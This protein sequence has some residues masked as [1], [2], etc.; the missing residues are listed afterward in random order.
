MRSILFGLMLSAG[1]VGTA[2]ADQVLASSPAWSGTNQKIGVC[3]LY[4]S[5]TSK[6]KINKLDIIMEQY[7]VVTATTVD[8]CTGATLQP[9]QT[10]RRVVAV[11]SDIVHSCRAQLSSAAG[12]RGSFEYRDRTNQ[13]TLLHVD[14]R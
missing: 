11:V 14:L 4:N 3:Y 7:G 6:I 2:A 12:I 13:N 10:C 9:G 8:N 1:L 5:G